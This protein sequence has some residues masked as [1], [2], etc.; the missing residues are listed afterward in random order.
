MQE[1]PNFEVAQMSCPSLLF[2]L[3][4]LRAK[5]KQRMNIFHPIMN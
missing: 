4:D 5:W 1:H 3:N 2:N